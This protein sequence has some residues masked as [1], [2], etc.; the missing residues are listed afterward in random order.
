LEDHLKSELSGLF[1]ETMLALYMRPDEY[2]AKCINDAIAPAGTDETECIKLLCT[3][4][5]HE[6]KVLKDAYKQS[7]H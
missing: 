2:E 5:N 1:L 6:L 7:N 3:K 4:D